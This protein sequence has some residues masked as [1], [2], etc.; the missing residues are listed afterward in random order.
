MEKFKRAFRQE[1][2][3]RRSDGIVDKYTRG[4][5][6]RNHIG[7]LHL[8]HVSVHQQSLLCGG[9]DAEYDLLNKSFVMWTASEWIHEMNTGEI[10]FVEDLNV[11]SIF[12][13]KIPNYAKKKCLAPEIAIKILLFTIQMFIA[14]YSL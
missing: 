5:K 8:S 3:N 2:R 13:T 9:V 10:Y 12:Q 1:N 11:K 14:K 6:M 4:S 7:V